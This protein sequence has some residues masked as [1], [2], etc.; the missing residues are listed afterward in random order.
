MACCARRVVPGWEIHSIV[1]I[2]E[3]WVKR[4]DQ[5]KGQKMPFPACI[6]LW[7]TPLSVPLRPGPPQTKDKKGLLAVAWSVWASERFGLV[8]IFGQLRSTR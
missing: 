3:V 2:D 1:R 8:K 6:C 7:R 4:V 5:A